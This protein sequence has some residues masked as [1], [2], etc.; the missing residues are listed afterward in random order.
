MSS[1]ERDPTTRD[2]SAPTVSVVIPAFTLDRWA[3]IVRAVESARQQTSPVGAVILSIDN[4]PELLARAEDEWSDGVGPPVLVVANRY[5]DHLSRHVV[6]EKVHGT[7][8]RF[9][10]GS[11]R[12]TGAEHVT[13]EIIAFMDDDAW[14][15]PEWIEHLLAVYRDRAVAAVGGASLPY[16]ETNRPRWFPPNYD[17]VFGCNYDGMPTMPAPLRRLIGANMSVRRDAFVA[18]GGFQGADF[19]DLNLCMRLAE[20]YGN[21]SVYYTP[22]AI[23]HHYVS[24]QR[25]TWRYF[26]RR[27]YFVNREK[28]RVFEGM[29]SAA[30]LAAEREF[31]WRL[32][33]HHALGEVRRGL[34]GELAAF[35]SAGAMLA[36]LA[37]AGAG[38]VRGQ[39]DKTARRAR[40][41]PAG[42]R[43]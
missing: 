22:H 40:K 28:V 2:P 6:H 35:L 10:A 11:A 14:A 37:L 33:R 20:S 39:M 36:G 29:G 27:C 13:S 34:K 21:E 1:A 31:V 16:Y 30:N 38:H 42:R 12:N 18:V 8:R 32:V 23:V 4:N 43:S 41:S 19:D 26:Y 15:E 9:G 24:A 5:D 3:L 25:V 7:S 17:W